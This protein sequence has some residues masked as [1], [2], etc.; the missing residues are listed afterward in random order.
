MLFASS[1]LE[2]KIRYWLWVPLAILRHAV[3]IY[4]KWFASETKELQTCATSR[5]LIELLCLVRRLHVLL[6]VARIRSSL[7]AL[8]FAN[9]VVFSICLPIRA[10]AD[11]AILLVAYTPSSV[12]TSVPEGRQCARDC[13]QASG[14]GICSMSINNRAVQL[15]LGYIHLSF[16]LGR[17]VRFEHYSEATSLLM[18]VTRGSDAHRLCIVAQTAVLFCP[19]TWRMITGGTFFRGASVTPWTTRY[20]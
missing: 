9:S 11:N 7:S 20:M 17:P 15:K 5:I 2:G 1:A 12:G 3:Y 10:E 13:I 19:S 18:S 6:P 16:S 4:E 14:K 8:R